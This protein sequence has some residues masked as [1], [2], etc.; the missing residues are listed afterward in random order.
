MLFVLQM[1]QTLWPFLSDP[2]V[3]GPIYGFECLKLTNS[4]HLNHSTGLAP[5]TSVEEGETQWETKEQD[6]GRRSV[7]C[8]GDISAATATLCRGAAWIVASTI[9][10]NRCLV[11]IKSGLSLPRIARRSTRCLASLAATARTQTTIGHL[12]LGRLALVTNPMTASPSLTIGFLF[13]FQSYNDIM[14]W[15]VFTGSKRE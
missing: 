3:P 7:T 13:Y 1:N 11:T 6:T 14:L 9:A 8:A 4:I 12:D 2:G 10:T 15:V 5:V